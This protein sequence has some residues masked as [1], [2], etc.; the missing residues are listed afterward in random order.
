MGFMRFVYN[1][2]ILYIFFVQSVCLVFLCFVISKTDKSIS[3]SISRYIFIYQKNLYIICC[4]S[5]QQKTPQFS[6]YINTKNHDAF[7]LTWSI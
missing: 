1:T 2:Q 7:Y 5:N 4:F 6:V 3:Y